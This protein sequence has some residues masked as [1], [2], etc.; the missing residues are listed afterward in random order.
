[1]SVAVDHGTAALRAYCR[2]QIVCDK[3]RK[4]WVDDSI[5]RVGDNVALPHSDAIHLIDNS[6]HDW[7]IQL[8]CFANAWQQVELRVGKWHIIID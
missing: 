4:V 6:V 7:I 1:M 8:F 3:S 2:Y 5:Q